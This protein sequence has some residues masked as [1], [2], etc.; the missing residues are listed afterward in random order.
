[1]LNCWCITWPVGFKMLRTNVTEKIK[2]HILCLTT[3]SVPENRVV[4]EIM[5]KILHSRTDHRWQ[6]GACS[7]HGGY[8][9]LQTHTQNMYYLLLFHGNNGCTNASQCYVMRTFPVLLFIFITYI[10]FFIDR[11][12]SMSKKLYFILANYLYYF[13]YSVCQNYIIVAISVPMHN[14]ARS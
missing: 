8:L 7:L 11:Q 12:S 9:R 5:C 2:T 6:H 10:A 14:H 13:I 1:M 4:C 3:F